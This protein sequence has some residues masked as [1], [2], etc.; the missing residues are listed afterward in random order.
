MVTIGA[1]PETRREKSLGDADESNEAYSCMMMGKE[2]G[3]LL[4]SLTCILKIHLS[5]SSIKVQVPRPWLDKQ[6]VS[7]TSILF[8]VPECTN[9]SP[10]S[11]LCYGSDNGVKGFSNSNHVLNIT[12][13]LL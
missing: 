2:A 8:K 4:C 11:L 3:V 12:P 10:G 5:I 13:L 9:Y 7:L 1:V 6:R